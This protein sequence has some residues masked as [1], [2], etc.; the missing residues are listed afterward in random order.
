MNENEQNSIFKIFIIKQI[1]M[2]Q[3]NVALNLCGPNCEIDEV[4]YFKNHS[5]GW[6]YDWSTQVSLE[7]GGKNHSSY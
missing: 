4:D 3:Q 1:Q 2:F 7:P 6:F 5:Q